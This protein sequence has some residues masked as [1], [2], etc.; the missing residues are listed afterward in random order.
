MPLIATLGYKY[1]SD[2]T[3]CLDDLESCGFD[4]DFASQPGNAD[5]DTC[6]YVNTGQRTIFSKVRINCSLTRII[7]FGDW[8]RGESVPTG[9]VPRL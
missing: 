2:A 5:I 1:V 7:N 4:F 8:N 3:D 6:K 9:V